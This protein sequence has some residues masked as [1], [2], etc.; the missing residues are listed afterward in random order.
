VAENSAENLGAKGE[1]PVE[2]GKGDSTL[3]KRATIGN[4]FRALKHV[5][6]ASGSESVRQRFSDYVTIGLVILCILSLLAA[7]SMQVPTGIRL[8]ASV[9]HHCG[10]GFL[11]HQPPGHYG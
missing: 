5:N 11:Y 7:V 2:K 9:L 10:G 8:F 6:E 3:P 4:F 1:G